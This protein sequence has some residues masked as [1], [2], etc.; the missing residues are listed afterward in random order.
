MHVVVGDA[1]DLDGKE[2]AGADVEGEVGDL[3]AAL[4]EGMDEFGSEVKAGG[5]SGYGT[6]VACIDGLVTFLIQT[7][8]GAIGPLDVG[9]QGEFAVAFGEGDGVRVE[10]EEAM[11]FGI[12]FEQ[13]GVEGVGI[14]AETEL[15]TWADAF[16]GA[17]EGPPLEWGGFF[18]EQDFYLA[19]GIGLMSAKACGDDLGIVEDEEVT[20]L[21]PALEIGEPGVVSKPGGAVEDEEA[22]GIPVEGRRLSDEFLGEEVIE[23]SDLHDEGEGSTG[24]AS[25]E[26][27]STVGESGKGWWEGRG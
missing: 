10:S 21:E 1:V 27:R 16:A 3:D 8:R 23:V 18:E 5:G 13:G 26:E 14:G 11:T 15:G 12:L 24:G 19:L 17:E 25:G 7:G 20:G 9:G 4:A 22:G 6:G 2:G